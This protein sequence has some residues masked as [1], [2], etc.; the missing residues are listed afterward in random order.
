MTRIRGTLGVVLC[1]GFATFAATRYAQTGAPWFTD[2]SSAT[3]DAQSS[4]IISW[5]NSQGGFNTNGSFQI[6]FSLG[7]MDADAST[8]MRTF[9]KTDNYYGDEECNNLPMPVPVGGAIEGETGYACSGWPDGG[10]CHLLVFHTPTRYLYEMY[11]ANIDAQGVFSSD[12]CLAVWNLNLSYA[13]DGRGETCTS[14]DA[15]GLPIAPLLFTADEVAA[16]AIEHAMRFA[17][18][19]ER[20]RNITY[21][22]PA[23]HATRAA[24]GGVNALPYGARLRLRANFPVSTLPAGARVVAVALQKYGMFLADGG[25]IPLMGQSDQFTT[26]KWSGLLG[27]RDM[28]GI[29]FADFEMV[30]GGTR[31][32]WAGNC[33]LKPLAVQTSVQRRG[34]A[35]AGVVGARML[36]GRQSVV[37][38]Y[39]AQDRGVPMLFDIRGKRVG[40]R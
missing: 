14:A 27:S 22:K 1:L 21:V 39:A 32:T 15:A 13:P 25:N 11:R 6:D 24:S 5:V 3:P 26:A 17:I 28:L 2:I 23:T 9:V 30:E 16:G 33:T 20:I 37:I 8:P 40:I 19:N 7:V 29:T 10:D 4:A 18:P 35:G 36:V 38:A 31:Y 34:S 12:A